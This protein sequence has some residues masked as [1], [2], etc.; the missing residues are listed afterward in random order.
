MTSSHSAP[1]LPGGIPE[2]AVLWIDEQV[3][4]GSIS[5][6]TLSYMSNL[7]SASLLGFVLP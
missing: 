6:V 5:Q 7:R 4:C 2:T 1:L 3:F